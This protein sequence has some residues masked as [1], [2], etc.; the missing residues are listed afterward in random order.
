MELCMNKREAYLARLEAQVAEWQAEIDRLK[1]K[2]QVAEAD[3]RIE[4][5]KQ[6]EKL[7]RMQADAKKRVQELR[8]AGDEAWDEAREGLEKAW[9]DL[10]GSMRSAIQRLRDA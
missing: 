3:A 2:A 7:E 9:D 8:D 6:I 5:T 1:A 10:Q 4:R